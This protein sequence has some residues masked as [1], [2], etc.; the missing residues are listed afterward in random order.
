MTGLTDK[1]KIEL[2][3]EALRVLNKDTDEE[4]RAK[5]RRRLGNEFE[6]LRQKNCERINNPLFFCFSRNK[7]ILLYEEGTLAMLQSA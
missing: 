4:V 6:Y 5:L 7:N 2:L 3:I 1:E